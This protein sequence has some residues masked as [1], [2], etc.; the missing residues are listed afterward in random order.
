MTFLFALFFSLSALACKPAP[1][2][3]CERAEILLRVPAFE[4]LEAATQEFQ[5]SLTEA[6]LASDTAPPKDGRPPQKIG[7]EQ[8]RTS[9]FN[10][11]FATFYLGQ[12]SKFA[13]ERKNYIC[14]AHLDFI[15]GLVK[16]LIDPNTLER[17]AVTLSK[18]QEKLKKLAEK[19]RNALDEF[20]GEHSK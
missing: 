18:D 10:N 2:S 15:D 4:K 11:H 1:L 6:I 13:K 9:C 8:G 5:K 19:T 12:I 14:H 16:Q 7:A 3:T 20:Q 17:K